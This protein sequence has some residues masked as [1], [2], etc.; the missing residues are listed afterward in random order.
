MIVDINQ[1]INMKFNYIKFFIMDHL[2][3]FFLSDFYKIYF[4]Y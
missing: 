4:R 3:A 1:L 2:P